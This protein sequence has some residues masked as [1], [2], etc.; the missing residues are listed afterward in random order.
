MTLGPALILLAA[1]ETARVSARNPLL[2]FGRVPLFYYVVHLY[3]IHLAAGLVFLPRF[4]SAAFHADPSALPP[5]F[6]VSL[7]VVYVVWGAAVLTMY[8][9][10]RW[11]SRLKQHGRNTLLSYL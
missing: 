4:G 11:F 3:L 7:G 5:G 10:C 2:V 9:L 1:L 8:P 6:G